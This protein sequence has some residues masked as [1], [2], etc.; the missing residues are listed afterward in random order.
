MVLGKLLI[1]ACAL[2]S[3]LVPIGVD[4][5]AF[6]RG[7]MRNPRWL[8]HAKLHCAMSFYA[9]I[10]LGLASLA[11]LTRPG[12]DAAAMVLAAFLGVA[13]WAG[14]L[15]AGAWPGTSYGFDGDPA[16]SEMR[17]P[18]VLGV[19][20]N[21]NAVLAAVLCVVAAVGLALLLWG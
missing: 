19:A 14:L 13:F 20:L 9:A 2:S 21:P 15:L 11:V 4:G 5:V 18:V 1:A 3:I 6:A 10:A 7:H 16:F 12:E 8:P 17:S